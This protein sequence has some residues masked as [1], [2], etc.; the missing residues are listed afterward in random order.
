LPPR[1]L[2]VGTAGQE[3]LCV[4]VAVSLL[5]AFWDVDLSTFSVPKLNASPMAFSKSD[6]RE[7][8][9]TIQDFHGQPAIP[10][11]TVK[12]VSNF[13]NGGG[14]EQGWFQWLKNQFDSSTDTP[15]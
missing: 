13:F 10:K 8:L 6:V 15:Q 5:L 11:R 2:V 3:D 7:R 1:V 4:A 9:A 12:E 14:R